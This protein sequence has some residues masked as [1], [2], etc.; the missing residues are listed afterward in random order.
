M[1]AEI[2][3]HL[4]DFAAA[5]LATTG[6]H[7]INVVPISIIESND[8]HIFLYDFFMGKTKEN[9]KSHPE[10][11]LTCWNGPTGVQIK[12]RVA[13]ENQ[14]DDFEQAVAHMKE[15]FPDRELHGLLRLTPLEAHDVSPGANAGQIFFA[16]V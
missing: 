7:G 8:T 5:A 16:K 10:V 4:T 9:I 15:R 3:K 14:G 11:A 2:Q 13:Y 6:P 12:A 1:N